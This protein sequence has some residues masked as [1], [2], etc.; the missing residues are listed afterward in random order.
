MSNGSGAISEYREKLQALEQRM[1]S[2]YD[3]AVMALS[4]G[5]LGISMAFLKDIALRQG[6]H[7]SVYGGGY[8][9]AAWISWGFS[10][11]CTLYSYYTSTLA[12][13]RAIKQ[14]DEEKIHTTVVGGRF[15]IVTKILNASA[16]SLFMVGVIFLVVFVWKNFP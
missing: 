10:V 9:L 4:G 8:L 7:Q 11:T 6:A 1:Q 5:A 2:Q 16:G 3:K 15:N 13:Q 12:L 14:T